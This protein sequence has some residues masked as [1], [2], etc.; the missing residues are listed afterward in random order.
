MRIIKINNLNFSKNMIWDL[1]S[2]K[3]C[4]IGVF[5]KQCIHCQNMKPEWAVLKNKL[6]NLKGNG[7]LLEIDSNQVNNIDYSPLT[8]SINGLPA[9]M[10][11]K[12]GKLKKEYKG[13]RSS[14]DMLKFFKPYLDLING[15]TRRKSKRRK[16]KRRK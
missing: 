12:N 6:K 8:N 14:N 15:K 1:L 16:S 13:D 4:I 2:K 9:L 7:I 3:T 5:S 10:V 11:F